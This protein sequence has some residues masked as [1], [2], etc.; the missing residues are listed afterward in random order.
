METRAISLGSADSTQTFS[1]IIDSRGKAILLIPSWTSLRGQHTPSPMK[2]SN[3]PPGTA[4]LTPHPDLYW[5]GWWPRRLR[6][7]FRPAPE[8]EELLLPPCGARQRVPAVTPLQQELPLASLSRGS[9]DRSQ[10]R[11]PT[12][13]AGMGWDGIWDGMGGGNTTHFNA[14]PGAKPHHEPHPPHLPTFCTKRV[15]RCPGMYSSSTQ[16]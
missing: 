8:A 3:S 13:A 14:W 2:P 4:N 16:P 10:H 9:Q 7:D 12:T 6:E 5:L 1:K 15:F 11:A